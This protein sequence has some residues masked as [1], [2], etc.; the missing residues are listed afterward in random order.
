[1]IMSGASGNRVNWYKFKI[2]Y[3]RGNSIPISVVE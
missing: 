2:N 1:L 3:R